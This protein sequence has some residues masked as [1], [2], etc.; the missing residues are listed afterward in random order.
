MLR[1]NCRIYERFSN[2]PSSAAQRL[3]YYPQFAGRFLCEPD[4][5]IDR[6]DYKSLLILY[7]T[8]G[9]ASL[10]YKGESYELNA[11]HFA[12]IDCRERHIY[13]PK[14]EWDFNFIHFAG[15][16]CFEMYEHIYQLNGS[17]LFEADS[18]AY[19]MLSAC[20]SA[21]KQ[22]EPY[23]EVCMSRLLGDILHLCLLRCHSKS[24]D[25][26]DSVCDYIKKHY[27]SACDTKTLSEKFGFSRSH[28]STQFKRYIGMSVHEYVLCSRLDAA[29]NLLCEKNCTVEQAAQ[30]T[31]FYDVG[32]FIRAFKRKEG[33]TPSH[34]RRELGG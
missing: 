17:V 34:Y 3:Y 28:F 22:T 24:H 2:T 7:T 16:N 10:L 12:L 14:G 15:Q 21:C 9:S 32:T 20:I 30:C 1:E 11:E 5:F 4:F 31:G 29:K 33:C 27:A 25:T 6:S 26:F 19:D 18:E 13:F 23:Q 8:K